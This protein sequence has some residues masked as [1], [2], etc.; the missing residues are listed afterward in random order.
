[1]DEQ[2]YITQ[3][4][5]IKI[6]DIDKNL[7]TL[8]N[9]CNK[10]HLLIEKVSHLADISEMFDFIN[11]KILEVNDKIESD[12]LSISDQAIKRLQNN[13]MVLQMLEPF[14]PYM[15]TNLVILNTT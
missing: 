7:S 3:Q 15:I 8:L 2:K 1:M 6:K 13:K 9:N 11:E 5:N 14:L 4:L 12:S 10:N